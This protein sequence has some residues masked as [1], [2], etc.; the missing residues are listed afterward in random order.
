M[1]LDVTW[2]S[3]YI[4]SKIFRSLHEKVLLS[5]LSS[6]EIFLKIL[7]QWLPKQW[8]YLHGA[9]CWSCS[10]RLST[11]LPLCASSSGVLLSLFFMLM[12]APLFINS[13]A[14]SVLFFR[15]A[16]CNGVS[17]NQFCLFKSARSCSRCLMTSIRLDHVA[18]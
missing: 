3:I 5:R 13:R 18:W 11:S 17:L 2:H 8:L 12:S 7:K 6:V 1:Q 14:I 16:K 15:A 10:S 9:L 4:S